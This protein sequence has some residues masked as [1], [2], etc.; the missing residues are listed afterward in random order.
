MTQKRSS[1]PG[2]I[3]AAQR[4][5]R[6]PFPAAWRQRCDQPDR[7]TEFQRNENRTKIGADSGRGWSATICMVA[8]RVRVSNLTLPELGRPPPSKIVGGKRHEMLKSLLQSRDWSC[9][10]SARLV[11]QATLLFKALPA[12]RG[13]GPSSLLKNPRHGESVVIQFSVTNWRRL[14]CGAHL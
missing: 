14:A 8:S 13:P 11:Q 1:K 2:D 10:L 4:V 3:A 9:R 5:L 7:S 12:S 6:H